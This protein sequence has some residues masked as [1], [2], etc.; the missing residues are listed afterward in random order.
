MD[1]QADGGL[2]FAI[3]RFHMPPDM[4]GLVQYVSGIE[5]AKQMLRREPP[6]WSP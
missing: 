4:A 5:R 1:I 6:L 3:P 2:A